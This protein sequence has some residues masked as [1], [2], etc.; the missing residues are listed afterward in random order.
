MNCVL[1]FY[2]TIDDIRNKLSPT[3]R[4]KYK[5]IKFTNA[6]AQDKQVYISCELL[7]EHIKN[8]EKVYL[9]SSIP[10]NGFSLN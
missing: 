2:I 7:E 1:N 10:N 8:D 4:E 9:F 6:I 3:D 5:Y